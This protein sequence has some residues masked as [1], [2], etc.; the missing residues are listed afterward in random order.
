MQL[1]LGAVATVGSV[2]P[3]SPQQSRSLGLECIFIYNPKY[4]V[5]C[6]HTATH[7]HTHW[8]PCPRPSQEVLAAPGS[9]RILCNSLAKKQEEKAAREGRKQSSQ[10]CL[11]SKRK[12]GRERRMAGGW[13]GGI[14][15]RVKVF[16]KTNKVFARPQVSSEP[17]HLTLW[18]DSFGSLP[19]THFG[20]Q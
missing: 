13:P 8:C 11:A 5:I 14:S 7:T 1:G 16:V 6:M 18:Q 17:R 3:R 9:G 15:Q 20:E 2:H 4:Q 10:R 12:G 19:V